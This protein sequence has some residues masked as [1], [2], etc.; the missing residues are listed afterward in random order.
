[1]SAAL[2]PSERDFEIYRLIR[3]EQCSTRQAAAAAGVSQTRVRQ[4]VERVANFLLSVVP[5]G[6]D[7]QRAARIRI[8]QVV[9]AER[10]DLLYGEALR[11][12]QDRERKVTT[13]RVS[14][15]AGGSPVRVDTEKSAANDLKYLLAAAKM[16]Q[17]AAQMPAESLN[18]LYWQSAG[19]LE[20]DCSPKPTTAPT[21]TKTDPPA[22]PLPDEFA[23]VLEACRD[24]RATPRVEAPPPAPKVASRDQKRRRAFLDGAA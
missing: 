18:S 14:A 6:T 7:E 24:F 17:L 23:A 13:S 12:W 10:I 5:E 2:P 16:A 4:I 19:P 9:A 20:E 22:A 11:V 3:V 15:E 1:M 8:A 21:P